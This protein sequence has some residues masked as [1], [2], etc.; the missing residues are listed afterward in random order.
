MKYK[1]KIKKKTEKFTV[2]HFDD[3][4]IK[5]RAIW[6]VAFPYCTFPTSQVAD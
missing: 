2:N 3:C 5:G 6:A 4:L 1:N